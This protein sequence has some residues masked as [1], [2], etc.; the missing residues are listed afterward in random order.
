VKYA[1]PVLV[2]A[3]IV[4]LVFAS[5]CTDI[6]TKVGVGNF[7]KSGSSSYG[8]D[9]EDNGMSTDDENTA[10]DGGGS[11][12]GMGDQGS[13]SVAKPAPPSKDSYPRIKP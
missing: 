2:S 8:K 6:L 4:L 9:S 10:G 7:G 3:M 1:I 13:G 12:G 5:G 11:K